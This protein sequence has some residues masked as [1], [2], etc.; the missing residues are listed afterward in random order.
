M[1][2][3]QHFKEYNYVNFF[4]QLNYHLTFFVALC[5][6]Q[7]KFEFIDKLARE[8]YQIKYKLNKKKSENKSTY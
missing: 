2:P 6:S 4:P 5:I 8:V 1:L 7:Y 3:V